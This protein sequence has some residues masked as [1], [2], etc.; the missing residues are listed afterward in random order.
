MAQY[1]SEF[2]S[3]IRQDLPKDVKE[4]YYSSQSKIMSIDMFKGNPGLCQENDQ[5]E[6]E[7]PNPIPEKEL[8]PSKILLKDIGKRVLNKNGK[9]ESRR[10]Y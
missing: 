4:R 3:K 6:L 1:N 10:K 5:L 8:L 2:E 9:L 7:E